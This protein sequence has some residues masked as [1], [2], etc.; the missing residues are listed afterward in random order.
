MPDDIKLPEPSTWTFDTPSKPFT[1]Y[2]TNPDQDNVRRDKLIGLYSADQMR[3]VV[4]ADRE[5][6]QQEHLTALTEARRAA[7]DEALDTIA[8]EMGWGRSTYL[9]L[10]KAIRMLKTPP[11]DAQRVKEDAP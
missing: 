10:A 3:A 11:A 7:L 9:E 1:F 4:L 8:H 6:R 5:G 2:T